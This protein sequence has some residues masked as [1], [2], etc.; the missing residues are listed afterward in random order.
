MHSLISNTTPDF[1]IIRRDS[2]LDEIC[3]SS[4]IADVNILGGS[5]L[6]VGFNG[7]PVN[8]ITPIFLSESFT[9]SCIRIDTTFNQNYQEKELFNR[10]K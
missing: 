5:I 8:E 3:V 2:I 9:D 7:L 6:V 4:N 1:V 10:M